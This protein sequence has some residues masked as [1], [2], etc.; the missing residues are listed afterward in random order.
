MSQLTFDANYYL[1]GVNTCEYNA[2]DQ[3]NNSGIL[4]TL[5]KYDI[6]P[7]SLAR[8]S[9]GLAIKFIIHSNRA[10]PELRNDNNF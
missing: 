9:R 2:K 4:C 10:D 1:C 7:D 5:K 8:K 3:I 6:I